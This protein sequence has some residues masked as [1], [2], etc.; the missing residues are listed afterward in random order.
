MITIT[1]INRFGEKEVFEANSVIPGVMES[2][3][4]VDSD[5]SYAG[6]VFTDTKGIYRCFMYRHAESGEN[7]ITLH[8]AIKAKCA[9]SESEVFASLDRSLV[10]FFPRHVGD[11]LTPDE[12]DLA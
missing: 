12:S 2:I 11:L 6:M 5:L 10:F 7:T 8:R 4:T 1:T 9:L 3:E